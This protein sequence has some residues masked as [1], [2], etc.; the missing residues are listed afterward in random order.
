M[1]LSGNEKVGINRDRRGTLVYGSSCLEF[2]RAML[3]IS[4]FSSCTVTRFIEVIAP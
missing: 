2:M 1:L 4:S 3:S